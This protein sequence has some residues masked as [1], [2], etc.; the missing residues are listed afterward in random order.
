MR[1]LRNVIVG[2]LALVLIV[3]LASGQGEA[4]VTLA[5]GVLERVTVDLHTILLA[6][7]LPA[8]FVGGLLYVSPWHRELAMRI[9]AG[10]LAV[11]IVAQLGPPALAWFGWELA[12]YGHRLPGS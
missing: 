10:A 3:N 6:I 7:A 8:L 2:F 12:A 9:M 11:L 1:E 5:V 4:M